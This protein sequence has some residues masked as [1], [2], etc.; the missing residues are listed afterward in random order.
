MIKKLFM[1][2][3]F[4]IMLAACEN[5]EQLPYKPA[6]S[7]PAVSTVMVSHGEIGNPQTRASNTMGQVALRFKDS[8]SLRS[9]RQSLENKT[10]EEKIKSV[11]A[12]GVSTLHEIAL[13]ADDELE[14]IGNTA[15]SEKQFRNL[16]EKYKAK[17]NGILVSNPLDEYDLSLYVPDGDNIDSYIANTDG[18]YVVGNR[19]VKVDLG[20]DVSETIVNASKAFKSLNSKTFTNFS[21]FR[22]NKFTRVFLQASMSDIKVRVQMHCDK[23]MWYGWKNDPSHSYYLSPKLNNIIYLAQD[24]Y[25]HETPINTLSMFVFDNKTTVKGSL[26]IILG[27]INGQRITGTLYA[28]TD[29]TAEHDSNGKMIMVAENGVMHPKCLVEKAQIVNVDLA[30]VKL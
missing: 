12:L 30:P 17:Y 1:A 11:E 10:E 6:N 16:Y 2:L 18:V 14:K 28:W 4:V 8:E 26:D 21:V 22:P 3:L 20:N 9:Y 7:L 23:K 24:S 19:V 29:L 27:K 13:Q 25:G 5:D 15:I